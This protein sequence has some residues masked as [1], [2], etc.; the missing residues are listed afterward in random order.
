MGYMAAWKEQELS[1]EATAREALEAE[2]TYMREVLGGWAAFERTCRHAMFLEEGWQRAGTRILYWKFWRSLRQAATFTENE[3]ARES[4]RCQ[5]MK[6]EDE[7]SQNMLLAEQQKAAAESETALMTK[8][9]KEMRQMNKI[10]IAIEAREREKAAK[11]E[12]KAERDKLRAEKQAKEEEVKAEQEATRKRQQAEQQ[13][14]AER[15]AER[16]RIRADRQANAKRK[17]ERQRL[18]AEHQAKKEAAKAERE[19]LR[20]EQQ[21][22]KEATK[23]ERKATGERTKAKRRP[24]RSRHINDEDTLTDEQTPDVVDGS[25]SEEIA[26]DR[27]HSRSHLSPE[28][29]KDSD[30]S[31]NLLGPSLSADEENF[32]LDDFMPPDFLCLS[33]SSE[34]SE[35]EESDEDETGKFLEFSDDGLSS[36]S[37]SG[38]GSST[39]SFSSRSRSSYSRV[40]WDSSDSWSGDSSDSYGMSL[41]SRSASSW[42]DESWSDESWGNAS[43]GDE[44]DSY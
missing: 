10:W 35:L 17:A 27:R 8:E 38:S 7:S 39:E 25:G 43:W 41:G 20:A 42:S 36:G 14:K 5:E 19:R 34:V 21:L 32:N 24:R 29:D 30:G 28:S 22:K 37:I 2:E 31:Q 11:A 12:R 1:Q 44:S 6:L 9:D 4:Q 16:D 33:D 40:G 13:A 3:R 26:S 18:R 15:K 23:T